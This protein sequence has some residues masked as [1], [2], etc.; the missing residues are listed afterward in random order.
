MDEGTVAS[1]D[2]ADEAFEVEGI[3]KWFDAVKGYG[4]IIPI[5]GSGDILIHQSCLQEAGH[6]VAH[7][8]AR[9]ICEAVKRPKGLQASKVIQVDNSSAVVPDTT[10]HD[11]GAAHV[12]ATGDFERAQVKWFNRAR[13]YGFVSQG[14]GMPDIFIH[15]ETL[16]RN[17]LREL[18]PGQRVQV[19]YGD[20]P[21]GL[22]VADIKEDEDH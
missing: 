11:D 8:G 14:P 7:E 2:A 6:D 1:S 16:R 18:R 15:M 3:V 10:L 4:F 5:D 19:R 13:G 22:M 17:N 20:G 9:V 21:K 12:V